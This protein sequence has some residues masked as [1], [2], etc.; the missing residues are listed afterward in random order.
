MAD[1]KKRKG[2]TFQ[3][4]DDSLTD[5]SKLLDSNFQSELNELVEKM[6]Y[7]E[8]GAKKR[9]LNRKSNEAFDKSMKELLED[10]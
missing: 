9:K 5:P 6:V 2:Y 1:I 3:V 8:E 10:E 4:E 7:G